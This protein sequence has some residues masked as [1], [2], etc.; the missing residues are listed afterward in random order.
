ML[1]L[2]VLELG[3]EKDWFAAESEEQAR[4]HYAIHYGF[5]DRDME[6]VDA[7]EVEDPSQVTVYLDEVDTETEEQEETSAEIVMS[8]MTK[9]GIV[10]ST[11]W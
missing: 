11:N 8:K 6:D 1:K 5:N 3:G 10:C 9:P 7:A 2:Y 4:K